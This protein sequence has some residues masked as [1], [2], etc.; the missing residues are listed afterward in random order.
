MFS[1]LVRRQVSITC[2]YNALW[3]VEPAGSYPFLLS[4]GFL[5]VRLS[6]Q[7]E[8]F[9]RCSLILE[10]LTPKSEFPCKLWHF[11]AALEIAR[12]DF[13]FLRSFGTFSGI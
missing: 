7:N 3:F 1:W 5:L 8:A 9:E 6:G 12:R 13:M 2:S 10:E 11:V 4:P